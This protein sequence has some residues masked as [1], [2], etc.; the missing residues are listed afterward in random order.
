VS[1]AGFRQEFKN[2]QLNT[3]NGTVFLVQN[4]NGCDTSLAGADRDLSAA[5]GA[6]AAKDVGAGVISQGVEVEA[7]L[8]PVRNLRVGAAVTYADTHYKSNLVGNESGAPLDPAL[9]KLPGDNLSNAP[10]WV[11]TSS[12]SWTPPI[13]G[14]GLS[15]LF[16]ID[17]RLTG[18]YNTGSDL[19]PQKEQDGYVLV[20]GRIGL[21]GP[22]ERWSVELWAQNL[23]N[24]DYTQVAFNSPFQAGASTAAFS[25][26]QFPGGRQIFSAFLAEPRTYG[27][28]V[29]TR[30]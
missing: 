23:L 3:F 30:F 9:R 17:G 6:C 15:G 24:T 5:T 22:D 8:A 11:V 25:D 14:T 28:T 4:I 21:R 16:Y 18:D 12:L 19:F 20:N 29:R 27:I 7:S 13:G 26:P 2:F 10:V 1:V